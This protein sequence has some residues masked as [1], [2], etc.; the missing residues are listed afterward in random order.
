MDHSGE[1]TRVYCGG[2][3][4]RGFGLLRGKYDLIRAMGI[5]LLSRFFRRMGVVGRFGGM[6]MTFGGMVM[7]VMITVAG[8][9]DKGAC[10]HHGMEN[11]VHCRSGYSCF[12]CKVN[13]CIVQPGVKKCR[14]NFGIIC[15]KYPI[16]RYGKIG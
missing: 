15:R 14:H 12:D 7:A 10:E 3:D 2:D 13:S 1:W 4:S 8:G 6:V 5:A 11:S 16:F 9:E